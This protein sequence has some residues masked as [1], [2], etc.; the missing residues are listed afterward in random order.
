METTFEIPPVRVRDI[1]LGSGPRFARDAMGPM[2]AFYV[3]WRFVGLAA[4]IV[5]ATV[6]AAAASEW[7]RRHDRSGLM[8]RIGLVL[9]LFQAV[10]GL[11]SGSERLYLA[12]PVIINGLYGLAFVGSVVLRRPLAGAFADEVY[13]FPDFV[14][15]S[16]T[17]RRVFGRV[18]LM[19]GVYLLGRSALRL[20]TLQSSSVEAFLGV[21][22]IT[23]MPL[24][25]LLLAAS[26]WYG[27]RGFRESEE[28]GPAIKAME[29]Q[30]IDVSAIDASGAVSAG[31][32]L[33]P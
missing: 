6:A 29:E 2:L 20:A 28:W 24:T 4:G 33:N 23:G 30:G 14:R 10:L 32:A 17:F 11:M 7:E 25:A 5:L 9:A 16:E 26:I 3:G 15:S 13:P 22:F 19:W 18:S 8:A 21:N 1:L 12:Q 27:A 31:A